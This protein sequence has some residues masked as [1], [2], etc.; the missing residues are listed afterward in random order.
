MEGQ[1]ALPRENPTDLHHGGALR[2]SAVVRPAPH[3]A[4][5]V[6]PLPSSGNGTGRG[7][8][9]R[10]VPGQWEPQAVD[11]RPSSVQA[12][13]VGSLDRSFPRGCDLSSGEGLEDHAQGCVQYVGGSRT[14]HGVPSPVGMELRPRGGAMRTSLRGLRS[15]A[16]GRS[17]VEWTR[18]LR[19]VG[20]GA[21]AGLWVSSGT[22]SA[23]E[24]A[25]P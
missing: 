13:P 24:Q 12:E 9:R 22:R 25:R 4:C 6:I 17:P 18:H 16:N 20:P 11:L 2:E 23:L 14:G 1:A 7:L 10:R 5:T 8:G 19:L 21:R 3:W 15:A